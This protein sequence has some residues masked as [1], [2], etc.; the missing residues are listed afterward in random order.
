MQNP[1]RNK[2]H[3]RT[4]MALFNFR[5]NRPLTSFCQNKTK[6]KTIQKHFFFHA[7]RFNPVYDC[8]QAASSQIHLQELRVWVWVRVRADSQFYCFTPLQQRWQ[9]TFKGK[10]KPKKLL[11]KVCPNKGWP[12]RKLK[13][14]KGL[15]TVLLSVVLAIPN[16]Y[17]YYFCYICYGWT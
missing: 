7:A 3:L 1:A 10:L 15:L 2:W 9:S 6:I 13:M 14:R 5:C 12:T 8:W 17:V 4:L 11:K 16:C